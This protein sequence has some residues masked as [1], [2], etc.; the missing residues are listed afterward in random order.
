MYVIG[1]RHVHSTQNYPIL[2]R[3]HVIVTLSNHT[4]KLKNLAYTDL[5]WPGQGSARC[6][7]TSR[8]TPWLSLGGHGRSFIESLGQAKVDDLQNVLVDGTSDQWRK[9]KQMNTICTCLG[10]DV[11]SSDCTVVLLSVGE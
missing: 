5:D 1:N 6:P 4:V 10:P 8:W 11:D 7:A 9:R 2:P 3:R